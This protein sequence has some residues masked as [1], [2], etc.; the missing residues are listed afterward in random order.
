MSVPCAK[1]DSFQ[2]VV[3]LVCLAFPMTHSML[4]NPQLPAL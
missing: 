1:K 2:M 4:D 3:V